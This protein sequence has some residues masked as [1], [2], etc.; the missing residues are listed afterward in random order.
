MSEQ[1]TKKT[2][3]GDFQTLGKVL[4]ISAEAAKMRYR[5]GDEQ[6]RKIIQ[7]II[8]ARENLIASYQQSDIIL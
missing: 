2:Q 4:G 3:Y 7:E 1:N 6:A 8:D 5:R